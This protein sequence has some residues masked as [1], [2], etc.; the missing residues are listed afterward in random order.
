[1]IE[2]EDI[3]RSE[4]LDGSELW[5]RVELMA[6]PDRVPITDGERTAIYVPMAADGS[7]SGENREPFA[8]LAKAPTAI[9][10]GYTEGGWFCEAA[11]VRLTDGE[12]QVMFVPL[13]KAA[14]LGAGRGQTSDSARPP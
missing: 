3:P 11:C 1:M 2:A 14:E 4:K 13:A 9:V 10:P 12:T 7:P 6:G 5:I 8:R